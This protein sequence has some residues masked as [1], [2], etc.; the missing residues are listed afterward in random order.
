MKPL[1]Q[2]LP[3]AALV[4]AGAIA[5]VVWLRPS[6]PDAVV[7]RQERQAIAVADSQRVERQAAV[8][9]ARRKTDKVV[10]DTTTS[11]P[12]IKEVIAEERTAVDSTLAAADRQIATRDRRIHTLET[13]AG[14]ILFVYSELGVST[15]LDRLRPGFEGE[16]GLEVRLDRNTRIQLGATTDREVQLKVR[17]DFR[18][19]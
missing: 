4:L 9:V 19:F 10:A 5:A 18:V 17:R 1:L 6:P 2:R 15:P 12:Q 14:G 16:A 8:P 3:I 13:R 7:D 11:R